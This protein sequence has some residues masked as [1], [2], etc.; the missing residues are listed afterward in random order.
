LKSVI[1]ASWRNATGGLSHNSVGKQDRFFIKE[2]NCALDRARGFLDSQV[3]IVPLLIDQ[4][5]IETAAGAGG[6]Q[7]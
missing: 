5:D 4:T 6:I 3:F 7:E 2:W 1:S